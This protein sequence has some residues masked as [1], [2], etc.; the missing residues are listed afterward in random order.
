MATR[1]T[2]TCPNCSATLAAPV[3]A[4]GQ[5]LLCP[6]CRTGIPVPNPDDKYIAVVGEQSAADDRNQLY[7]LTENAAG[8]RRQLWSNARRQGRRLATVLV[9]LVM[10][11]VVI[12]GV[13]SIRIARRA[14]IIDAAFRQHDFNMVL[15]LAP[16]HVEAQVGRIR[17]QLEFPE[18]NVAAAIQDLKRLEQLAPD[19]A[20]HAECLPDLAIAGSF[21]HARSGRAEAAIQELERA[22]SLQAAD[23]KVA[24]VKQMLIDGFLKQSELHLRDAEYTKALASSDSALKLG[25]NKAQITTVR[26]K[27]LSALAER[28][29]TAIEMEV[30]IRGLEGLPPDPANLDLT[31]ELQSLYLKRCH[32]AYTGGFLKAALIYFLK[33]RSEVPR[34]EKGRQFAIDLAD[35]A[36][37]A[38]QSKHSP[39]NR[40]RAVAMVKVHL[41]ES[42]GSEVGLAI[43]LRLSASLLSDLDSPDRDGD[44]DNARQQLDLARIQRIDLQVHQKLVTSLAQALADRCIKHFMQGNIQPGVAD[45]RAAIAV[46]PLQRRFVIWRLEQAGVTI[47]DE[48]LQEPAAKP[49]QI[50]SVIPA[51]AEAFSVVR[52]IE[53]LSEK[54]DQVTELLSMDP[55]RLLDV[56]CEESGIRN[57]LAR[58]G[59]LAWVMMPHA[60]EG[61]SDKTGFLYLLP[62]NDFET[63]I[64]PIRTGALDALQLPA[65]N[66]HP[67][68]M[69]ERDGLAAELDRYGVF[70]FAA[71]RKSLAA[72]L[73]SERN[74]LTQIVP[75]DAW[76]ANLDGYFVLTEQGISSGL[77][78]FEIPFSTPWLKILL[79]S[80]RMATFEPRLYATEIATELVKK[81]RQ[82][83]VGVEFNP[84]QGVA[85]RSRIWL[86][87]EVDL[88]QT[89]SKSPGGRERQ[90]NKLPD[91]PILFAAGGPVSEKQ[92]ESLALLH[93]DYFPELTAPEIS[94]TGL[95]FAV[96]APESVPAGAGPPAPAKPSD[97][98]MRY[99]ERLVMVTTVKDSQVALKEIES[100]VEAY[101]Q[102]AQQR[103]PLNPPERALKLKNRVLLGVPL[104]QITMTTEVP[105]L[106]PLAAAFPLNIA[107]PNKETLVWTLGGDEPLTRAL[108]P[109]LGGPNLSQSAGVR[110]ASQM[111]PASTSSMAVSD[112][113]NVISEVMYRGNLDHAKWL[114][115]ALGHPPEGSY[116]VALGMS[117]RTSDLDLNLSIPKETLSLLGRLPTVLGGRGLPYLVTPIGDDPQ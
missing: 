47:P 59:S 94:L 83:A 40:E 33:S 13:E 22:I 55:P 79:N 30:A 10:I 89:M 12:W 66:L 110:M 17:Q 20:I 91:A 70:T 105:E 49:D 99:A 109:N 69:I 51:E 107:A 38:Y 21:E 8:N 112:L 96:L 39:E 32:L 84:D 77:R 9:V 5:S 45:F 113:R 58:D 100:W 81:L 50:W 26:L 102:L 56:A 28:A 85:I 115:E 6:K 98:I 48:P 78:N 87:P 74:V 1:I 37:A 95:Q 75:F 42:V 65:I 76:G 31:R 43:N 34:D 104:L 62:T 4:V 86:D 108:A 103:N 24:I 63:M 27:T 52:N 19:H 46:N 114:V 101:D 72:A 29:S 111:L 36:V 88:D 82:M 7:Q 35:T 23:A 3:S 64:E 97:H 92:C 18:S 61:G 90:L 54:V 80:S 68:R 44:I 106:I 71:D 117:W 116:P 2:I 57:G 15:A 53:S 25:G 73:A 11:G 93:D 41:K 67:V 16:D 60:K 14:K